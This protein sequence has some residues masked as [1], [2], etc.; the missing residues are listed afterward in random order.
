MGWVRDLEMV[1][2]MED[3]LGNDP[4][5]HLRLNYTLTHEVSQREFRGI[6]GTMSVGSGET[7]KPRLRPS[8]PPPHGQ[9]IRVAVLAHFAPICDGLGGG[10]V[11]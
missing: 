3:P 9:K 10:V 4:H 8:R 5:E 11:E 1:W 6:F 2:R 7:L